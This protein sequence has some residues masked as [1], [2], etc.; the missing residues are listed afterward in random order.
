KA[1]SQKPKA[2]SQKP[3]AKS[4]KPKA[5][6]QKPKAKSQK[7]RPKAKSKGKKPKAKFIC[8][9]GKSEHEKIHHHCCFAS[10]DWTL[11]GREFSKGE[12]YRYA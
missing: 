2:K 6:S 4:Q 12:P 3:K 1:K 8:F 7:Q 9:S 5:K 11:G 10:G